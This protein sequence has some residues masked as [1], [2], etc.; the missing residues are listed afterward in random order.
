MNVSSIK[1]DKVVLDC[2][3]PHALSLFYAN[4]LGWNKGY[5]TDDFV[6][7]GS[8]T[9]TVDSRVSKKRRLRNASMA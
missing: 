6:I 4:L 1:F 2:L 3:D 5:V 8:A 9:S 7:I